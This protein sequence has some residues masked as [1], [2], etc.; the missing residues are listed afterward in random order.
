[1]NFQNIPPVE[2]SKHFLEIAFRRAREKG[3]SKKLSGNWLQIIR[4]K[5]GLKLDIIK[6]SIVPRLKKILESF[7]D[8]R[9]LPDFYI[10]LMNLT[11]EYPNYKKSLGAVNWAIGK[12]RLIHKDYVSKIIRSK[13][14]D[15]IKALSKEFYGRLASVLKQIDI[16]LRYLES[17]R[18]IMRS[19]PDIKDMFTVC[20]YGF[21]NVGKT[22]LLNKLAGTTAEVAAYAFTTKRINAGYF[23]VGGRKVQILDVPG[24]L[25]R[26]EKMNDIELQA[27]LVLKELADLIIYVFDI[28]EF[29]GYSF[30]KQDQL[31]KNLGKKKALVYV[32]KKDIL[33]KGVIEA[34]EYPHYSLEEIKEKIISLL[35]EEV[36]P[37]PPSEEPI[38]ESVEESSL[39]SEE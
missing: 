5:E 25:A 13:D 38:D 4:Q 1:M 12:T 35:P 17:C 32:S 37:L 15:S 7:P 6:D 27:D 28:S 22:T 34:F 30:K 26:K 19:Y 39:S 8:S 29:C 20:I 23:R 2:T 10:Q 14:R 16:N 11:L 21:P 24:T 9:A 36:V 3:I 31:F 33:E 18:R